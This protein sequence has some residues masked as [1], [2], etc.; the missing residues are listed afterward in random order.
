MKEAQRETGIN[1]TAISKCCNHKCE[2]V[3]G[4][5]WEFYNN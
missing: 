2:T 1:N 3:G 5:H 4:F